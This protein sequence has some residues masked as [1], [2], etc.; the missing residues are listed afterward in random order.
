MITKQHLRAILKGDKKV[1]K[2]KDVKFCNCPSFDEIGV[3]ALYEKVVQN[4]AVK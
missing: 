1:M 3:K 4:P 2:I